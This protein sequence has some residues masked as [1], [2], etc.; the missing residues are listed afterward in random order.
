M[1]IAESARLTGSFK[2]KQTLVKTSLL[3][4]ASTFEIVSRKSPAM[5]AEISDWESGLVFSVGVLPDGPAI[6][7][8][9]ETDGLH[10]LGKGHLDPKLKLLFK[11]TDSALMARL[12]LIGS[13]TAFA[14]HRAIVH[15]SLYE[16]MQVNRAMAIV[17]KYLMPGLILKRITKRPPPMSGRDYLIKA[18]VMS[19]LAPV[20]IK[21]ALK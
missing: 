9:K 18:Q 11:S 21:N 14:Q 1:S 7:M 15:G 4:L 5:R 12:G 6:T 16:A 20:M 3:A 13:H 19:G 10:Y 8:R 2:A 17:Q